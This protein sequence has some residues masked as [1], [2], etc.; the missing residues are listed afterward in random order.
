VIIILLGG[1]DKPSKRTSNS[2]PFY[3]DKIP[4]SSS[5]KIKF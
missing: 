3:G 2:M 5:K 1:N 4:F